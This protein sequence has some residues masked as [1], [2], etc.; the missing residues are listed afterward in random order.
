M[1]VWELACP[2]CEAEPTYWMRLSTITIAAVPRFA[3]EPPIKV[4]FL[5]TVFGA[6][7][8]KE[9]ADRTAR[10]RS[11]CRLYHSRNWMPLF[12]CRAQAPH[13]TSHGLLLL[14][15]H[16]FCPDRWWFVAER[17]AADWPERS[18]NGPR[19]RS[20]RAGRRHF[21]KAT[22]GSAILFMVTSLSLSI[23]ATKQAGAGVGNMILT[24]SSPG[25]DEGVWHFN[26]NFCRRQ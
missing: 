23:M 17:K 21:P 6:S 8:A 3:A 13:T 22:T 5:S 19:P 10:G 18:A 4:K 20:V 2:S 7:R 11:R 24:R 26:Q 12:D 25:L 1:L 9:Q 15:T 14:T 16:V